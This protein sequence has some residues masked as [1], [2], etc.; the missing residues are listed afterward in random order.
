MGKGKKTTEQYKI[1]LEEVNKKNNTNIKLKDGVEYIKSRISITHIC[2]CGKE[3]KAQPNNILSGNSTCCKL[4][5]TFAEWGINNLG[6]V[7]LEKYWDYE[8]NTVDPWRISWCSAEVVYIYCKKVDYHGSYK[9][10]CADFTFK[11]CRCSYCK[12]D[13]FVHP[14]QSYI[15]STNYISKQKTFTRTCTINKT[16]WNERR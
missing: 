13:N 5:C 16:G 7:F 9:I 15:G 2:T 8:K 6:E 1:E 3:W 11:G 14:R 10:R 12:G 4:C